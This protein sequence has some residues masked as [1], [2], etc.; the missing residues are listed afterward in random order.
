MKRGQTHT[1]TIRLLLDQIGPV[2]RF[3]ENTQIPLYNFYLK[4]KI[5]KMHRHCILDNFQLNLTGNFFHN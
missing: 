4:Q 3:N 5:Q 1:Q 2:G